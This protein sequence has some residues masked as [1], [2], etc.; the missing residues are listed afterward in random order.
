MQS[1]GDVLIFS[2]LVFAM[3]Y[4]K[5]CGFILYVAKINWLRSYYYLLVPCVWETKDL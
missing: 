3:T 2:L 5:P 1:G 4:L